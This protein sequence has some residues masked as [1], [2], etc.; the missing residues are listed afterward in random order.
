MPYDIELIE[1][2]CDE[3]GFPYSKVGDSELRIKIAPDV[4]MIIANTDD[5][6]TY[7]GFTDACG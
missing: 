1:L 5:D 2:A 6:D 4:E 3:C 7:W